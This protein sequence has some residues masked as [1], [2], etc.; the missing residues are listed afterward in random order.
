MGELLLC[1]QRLAQTPYYL[2]NMSQNVFSVEEICY[3]MGRDPYL[4]DAGFAD[5]RLCDW[6][7]REL[8]DAGLAGALKA[9]LPEN[10]GTTARFAE[11]LLQSCNYY[12]GETASKILAEV[13]AMQEMTPFE[14]GKIRADRCLDSGKYE[15]A[16]FA[17]EKLLGKKEDCKKQPALA[18]NVRHNLGVAYAKLFLFAEAADC[19][20][21]AYRENGNPES[22][23][24][25]VAACRMA[26]DLGR[27]KKYREAYRI[28]DA[29]WSRAARLAEEHG[30]EDDMPVD[31]EMSNDTGKTDG[32]A[33]AAWMA[34]YKRCCGVSQ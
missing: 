32:E 11:L 15:K 9:A 2:E 17:Y 31:A 10:G 14:C 22:L 8:G 16:A 27:L 3:L 30:K 23:A 19:F 29:E 5:V 4:V 6:V 18:G 12:D 21:L 33:A 1:R 24:E 34:E 25:C 26:H 13:G 7:E 20:L 28:P